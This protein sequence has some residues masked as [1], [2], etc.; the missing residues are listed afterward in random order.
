MSYNFSDSDQREAALTCEG[1]TEGF[2]ATSAWDEAALS[3]ARS[4]RA[5]KELP[6]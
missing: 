1:Q 5:I 6:K 3:C 2:A 4:I